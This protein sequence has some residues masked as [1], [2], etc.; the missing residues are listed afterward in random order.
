MNYNNKLGVYVHGKKD[1]K[2]IKN[3]E[4]HLQCQIV[5]WLKFQYPSVRFCATLGGVRVGIGLAK[6]L[7]RQGYCA[8]I[9]DLILYCP[10]RY[11]KTE[12]DRMK[13]YNSPNKL[14]YS[15]II[16]CGLAIEF[17]VGKN[18]LSPE[19][20]EWQDYLFSNGYKHIIIRDF[21][22]GIK[23]IKEYLG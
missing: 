14:R 20:Q 10:Q 22:E 17:K 11:F 21:D 7:K 15:H 5:S 23:A 6:K 1:K 9:P 19:Q 12:E 13:E 3:E 16:R 18:K 8:G 4:F 2:P